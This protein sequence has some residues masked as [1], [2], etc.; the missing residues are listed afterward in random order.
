MIL[1]NKILKIFLILLSFI[2]LI[3]I[4]LVVF[5]SLKKPK[6]EETYE[7]DTVKYLDENMFKLSEEKLVATLWPYE[8][9]P[10]DE[11]I[12]L[13]FS[14]FEG[15]VKLYIEKEKIALQEEI[16]FVETEYGRYAP[17]FLSVEIKKDKGSLLDQLKCVFGIEDICIAEV[18][19]FNVQIYENRYPYPTL[20]DEQSK[21][22]TLYNISKYER[23]DSKEEIVER[24]CLNL[25]SEYLV[26][27]QERGKIL[28]T[29]SE[30]T[31]GDISTSLLYA[32]L[33]EKDDP[34]YKQ[35]EEKICKEYSQL[36]QIDVEIMLLPTAI[37]IYNEMCN[38]S[39]LVPINQEEFLDENI[40][41]TPRNILYL[42]NNRESMEYDEK[43]GEIK[44]VLTRDL[45]TSFDSPSCLNM[46]ICN[47]ELINLSKVIFDE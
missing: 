44:E 6:W 23:G 32:N 30:L 16:E 33:L 8:I 28:N 35:M 14:S 11:D 39:F 17:V 9:L 21:E 38:V 3:S 5:L 31:C 26:N 18:D 29:L 22:F 12:I 41:Q 36:E 13:G 4:L 40:F 24:Q 20:T 42:L 1:R 34:F 7:N 27:I 25:M 47:P 46:Y 2:L 15:D 37:P 10:F 45:F 43:I 19:I